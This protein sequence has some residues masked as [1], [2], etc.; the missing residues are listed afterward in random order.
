MSLAGFDF[1]GFFLGSLN[2]P[3]FLIFVQN[4]YYKQQVLQDREFN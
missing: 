3:E 1:G 4:V 2:G